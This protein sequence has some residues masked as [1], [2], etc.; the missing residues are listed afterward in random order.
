MKARKLVVIATVCSL[1]IALSGCLE[2][3]TKGQI[4]TAG[5]GIIG[6]IIGDALCEDKEALCIAAGAFI[7]GYIGNKFGKYLDEQEQKRMAEV[8]LN[9]LNTGNANSW[10]SD[11]N[12]TQVQAR[13]LA[14]R[15]TTETVK[16]PVLKKK[17]KEVPPLEIIGQTYE[18]KGQSNLRGG[19]STDYEKVGSLAAGEVI[20]VVGKVKGADWYLISKDGVGSGFI[21]S[22]LVKAAP[23]KVAA[24]SKNEISRS[25]IAQTNVTS[26]RTCKTVEQSVTLA[27]GTQHSETVEACRGVNGWEEAA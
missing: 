7:G 25:D 22:Y 23:N 26:D 12:K 2:K 27:D 8:T 6:A 14:S 20:N 4:G 17:I 16:V 18:A 21:A 24:K 10:T 15:T 5:G 13:Q 3:I 1:S 19:P 11:K 9:T